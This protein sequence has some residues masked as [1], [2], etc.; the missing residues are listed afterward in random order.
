MFERRESLD[1]PT[2]ALSFCIHFLFVRM[3]MSFPMDNLVF[4]PSGSLQ[5]AC[6]PPVTKS[7]LLRSFLHRCV[8]LLSFRELNYT[9]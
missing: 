3:S 2:T 8:S 5:V 4:E 1:L 6:V 7:A 9:F